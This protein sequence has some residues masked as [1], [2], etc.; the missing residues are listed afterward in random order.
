MSGFYGR[1][2][3][4]DPNGRSV[5]ACK[6]GSSLELSIAF[7]AMNRTACGLSTT[8]RVSTKGEV[9]KPFFRKSSAATTPSLTATL[10]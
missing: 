6:T 10:R 7:F 3:K 2:L 1:I 9:S 5:V 4:L 8:R